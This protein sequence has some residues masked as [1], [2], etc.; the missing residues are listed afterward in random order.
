MRRRHI[1][2]GALALAVVVATIGGVALVMH[3]RAQAQADG[4]LYPGL[5]GPVA[6][7]CPGPPYGTISHGPFKGCPY[8]SDV[9][10]PAIRPRN[11]CTPSF[12]Q[13]DVRDVLADPAHVRESLGMGRLV[14]GQPA[15]TRVIFLTIADLGRATRD[16]N[17]EINYPSDMLVCYAGLRG[18]FNTPPTSINAA[19][20]IFDAHTGNE[21]V[22]GLGPMLG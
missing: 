1:L 4:K 8:R 10:R 13:Q 9:G 18:T 17:W 21:L 7:V 3:I 22:W 19:F 11:D 14:V 6:V 5:H 2:L 15:V 12:P 16:T 20:V